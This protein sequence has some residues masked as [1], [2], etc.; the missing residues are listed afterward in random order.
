MFIM[1]SQGLF[2]TKMGLENQFWIQIVWTLPEIQR[3]QTE[4]PMVFFRWYLPT[5]LIP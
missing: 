2:M 1:G 5:E 4:L 3:I